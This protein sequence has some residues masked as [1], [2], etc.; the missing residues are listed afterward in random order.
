MLWDSHFLFFLT[1]KR[2]KVYIVLCTIVVNENRRFLFSL[3]E[4]NYTKIYEYYPKIHDL[5]GRVLDLHDWP[6]IDEVTGDFDRLA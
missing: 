3:S 2:C 6:L 5:A 1:I 4:Q